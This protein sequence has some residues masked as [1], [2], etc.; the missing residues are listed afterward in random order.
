M[1]VVRV[2][3]VMQRHQVQ[4]QVEDVTKVAMDAEE[5]RRTANI[6]N[7]VPLRQPGAP[8]RTLSGSSRGPQAALGL[9]AGHW[10]PPSDATQAL[11][12]WD[13]RW[14]PQINTCCAAKQAVL[15]RRSPRDRWWEG[16]ERLRCARRCLEVHID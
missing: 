14:R 10:P 11:E 9:L 13:C 7:L 4:V 8:P 2:M 15:W 3:E 5:E 6:H 16:S 12:Q 1:A